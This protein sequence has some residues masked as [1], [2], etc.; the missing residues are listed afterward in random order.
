MIRH[1]LKGAGSASA[2]IA[3]AL[4]GATPSMAQEGPASTWGSSVTWQNSNQ[5]IVALQEAEAQERAQE[6]G[7]GPGSTNVTNNYNGDVT[8]NTTNNG[9]VSNVSSTN[10]VNLT[11]NSSSVTNGSGTVGITYQTGATSYNATQ[12]ATA[13]NAQSENGS[14]SI[15]ASGY[16]NSNP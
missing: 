15:A 2:V 14:N 1:I 9:S 7:Y 13:Q 10:A 6:D 4:L 3:I 12:N 11:T 8:S 5:R 16:A